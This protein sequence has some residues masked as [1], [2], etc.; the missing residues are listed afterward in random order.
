MHLDVSPFSKALLQDVVLLEL[1]IQRA[2]AS[3]LQNVIL[4][5]DFSS[6]GAHLEHSAH[7]Q[8]VILPHASVDFAAEQ[9]SQPSWQDSL[10]VHDRSFCAHEV[11]A[12][13]RAGALS[14]GP[15]PF[16]RG[17]AALRIVTSTRTLAMVFCILV[18]SA[19]MHARPVHGVWRKTH[20]VHG[21][22]HLVHW[23]RS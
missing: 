3:H 17:R 21:E 12:V 18:P 5:H 10:E 8:K 9:S 20:Q 13:Q 2:D 23:Y 22:K 4:S 15:S 11:L 7:S 6:L 1:L 16:A 14:L 19:V